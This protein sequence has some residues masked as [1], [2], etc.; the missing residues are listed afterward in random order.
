MVHGDGLDPGHLN[1]TTCTAT[2]VMDA[3]VAEAATRHLVVIADV[4]V[5]VSFGTTLIRIVAILASSVLEYCEQTKNNINHLVFSVKHTFLKISQRLHNIG[6]FK[7]H[8]K[9]AP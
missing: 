5:D 1:T 3:T 6:I 4:K 9:K 8:L 7:C 2:V